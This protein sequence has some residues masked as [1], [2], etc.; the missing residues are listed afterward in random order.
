MMYCFYLHFWFS[1]YCVYSPFRVHP[2][3]LIVDIPLHINAEWK[4]KILFPS[5]KD[6]FN[7]ERLAKFMF[8]MVSPGAYASFLLNQQNF[9][10]NSPIAKTAGFGPS[11][12][13]TLG[14]A[15]NSW[16]G[17]KLDSSQMKSNLIIIFLYSLF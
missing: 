10:L 14:F 5:K 8:D 15:W 13:M 4:A 17:L 2:L 12:S 3:F 16:I 6:S 11:K 1:F 9:R 7:K